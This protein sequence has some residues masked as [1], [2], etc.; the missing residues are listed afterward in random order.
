MKSST[1]DKVEGTFHQVK[2]KVKEVAGDL[3]D[4]PKLEAEGVAEKTAGVVQ[5]KLGQVKKVWE[6]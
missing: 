1:Q 3:I 4:S 5:K 6:K 2:G